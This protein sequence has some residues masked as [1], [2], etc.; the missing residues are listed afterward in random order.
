MAFPAGGH[1]FITGR[2]R[3]GRPPVSK[4]RAYSRGALRIAHLPPRASRSASCSAPGVAFL[5]FLS[6]DSGA[7]AERATAAGLEAQGP[8]DAPNPAGGAIRCAFIPFAGTRVEL[9]QVVAP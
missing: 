4:T 9:V 3:A 8:V 6:R 5:T 1:F 7:A 2:R